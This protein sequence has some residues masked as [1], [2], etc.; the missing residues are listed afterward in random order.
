MDTQ[1]LELIF[2]SGKRKKLL[3]FLKEGLKTI[4]EIKR[5]LDVGAMGILS[6]L[7]RLRENSPVIKKGDVHSLS[8][9]DI[10]IADR[11][12]SRV[13]LLSFFEK[14]YD[15]WASHS[16]DFKPASLWKKNWRAV[17]LYFFRSSR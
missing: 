2:L 12:Q 10:A 16:V 13:D 14:R 1:F 17:R 7:K 3:L 8:S 11:M 15:Y 5:H 9:F 4:A 6:Q